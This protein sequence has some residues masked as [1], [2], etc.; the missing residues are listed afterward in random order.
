MP[1]QLKLK[2]TLP[3]L[4]AVPGSGLTQRIRERFQS[5]AGTYLLDAIRHNLGQD[6]L[7]RLTPEYAARKQSLKELRRFPGKSP[8]QPLILSGEMYNALTVIPDG[9]GF[10]VQ[11]EDGQATD[12]G[13]DYAEH[14]EEIAHFLEKGLDMVE[15]H[16]DEMLCDIIVQE[17][18]L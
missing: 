15:G 1:Y 11:V 13:F 14:W 9:N 18:T 16:L 2:L 17:M 4:Q 6:Y 7:Y 10:V 3:T 5:E 12:G 8:D